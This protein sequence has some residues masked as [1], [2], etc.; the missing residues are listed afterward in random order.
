MARV[1]PAPAARPTDHDAYEEILYGIEGFL[2][3]TVD[4]TPIEVGP[5]EI[6]N[7]ISKPG[8]GQASSAGQLCY[9]C[10]NHDRWPIG[11]I[12]SEHGPSHAG[13]LIR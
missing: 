1:R 4:G 5:V 8:L 3:W 12:L 11:L 10:T 2:T 13:Q 6:A 9:S 7:A